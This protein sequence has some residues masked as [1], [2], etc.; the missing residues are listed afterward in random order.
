MHVAL[1]V[2]NVATLRN[3]LPHRRPCSSC[4][5]AVTRLSSCAARV[6]A[7]SAASRAA[8]SRTARR[9]SSAFS[10]PICTIG[11]YVKRDTACTTGGSQIGTRILQKTLR[12]LHL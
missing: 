7:P 4:S 11:L 8:R 5:A 12:Q 3:G 9:A 10:L 1:G 6:S 2:H